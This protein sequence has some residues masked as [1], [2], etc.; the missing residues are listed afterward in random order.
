[1]IKW[2]NVYFLCSQS[3]SKHTPIILS[4][5][6]LLKDNRILKYFT[7]RAMSSSLRNCPFSSKWL[8]LSWIQISCFTLNAHC[9]CSHSLAPQHHYSLLLLSSGSEASS[10]F[11]ARLWVAPGQTEITG[12][13]AA[14]MLPQPSW[15]G[16]GSVRALPALPRTCSPAATLFREAKVVFCL[17]QAGGSWLF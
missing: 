4:C 16:C 10:P 9:V 15:H 13:E 8:N 6:K 11:V 1:M 14:V 3:Y 2:H 5:T 12:E 7:F 17:P